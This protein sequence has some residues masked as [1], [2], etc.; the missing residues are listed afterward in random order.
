MGNESIIKANLDF[1]HLNINL[2]SK[3]LIFGGMA[4]EYYNLRKHGGDIDMFVTNKDY[5]SLAKEYPDCRID[6]WGN[7]AVIIEKYSFNLYVCHMDYDFYAVGAIEHED[8]LVISYDRLYFMAASAMRSEPDV[9]KRVD[10]FNLVYWAY[11]DRCKNPECIKFL[12]KH[13]QIYEKAPNGTIYGGKYL[14][15]KP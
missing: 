8:F 7:L 6:I 11:Y 4:M 12:E 5:H 1:S 3:P 9:K 2:L 14:N 15:I 13:R 10:D